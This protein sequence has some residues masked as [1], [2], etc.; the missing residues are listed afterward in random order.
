M[1]KKAAEKGHKD[2]ALVAA[3]QTLQGLVN[4]TGDCDAA[5]K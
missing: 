2:A 5:L 3:E 1:F 4:R